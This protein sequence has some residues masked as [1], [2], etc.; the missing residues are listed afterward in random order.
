MSLLPSQKTASSADVVGIFDSSF[1]QVFI[2]ARP[3][4]VKILE[5]SQLM[6]HP[7]ETG[8]TIVDHAVVLPIEIEMA[9]LV[10]SDNFRDVYQQIR[11]AW[12]SKEKFTIQTK[13]GSY[14]DMVIMSIP[15]DETPEMFDAIAMAVKF[16]EAKFVEP[17]F[18]SLPPSA[19]KNKSDSDTKNAGQKQGGPLSDSQERKSSVL[20]GLIK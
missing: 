10:V 15:H 6:E 11:Q 13:T 16:K 2:D 5:N 3:L 7:L 19:V 9:L 8:S 12:L 17:Q 4:N 18:E 1:R 20:L 14:P